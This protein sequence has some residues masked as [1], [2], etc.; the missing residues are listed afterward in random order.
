[1]ISPAEVKQIASE[2]RFNTANIE[3]VLRLIELLSEIY[4][5]PYLKSRF[6]LKGGTAINVF[7]FDIPRLSV[8]IDLNYI[9]S[10]EKD[11]MLNE[12]S[13]IRG[14]LQRI[15]NLQRYKSDFTEN[16]GSDRFDLWYQNIHGNRDRIKLEINYLLRVPLLT[17]VVS[18]KRKLFKSIPLPKVTLL[19]PEE[20]FATKI[21]ALFARHAARDLYD[22]YHLSTAQN[23][24]LN[25]SLLKGCT[26]F[27][28]VIN[29]ED[30]RKMSIDIIDRITPLDIKRTLYPLLQREL[31]F[32]LAK[33]KQRVRRS[34]SPL[35]RFTK[36]E[37]RFIDLFFEGKYEPELIF[38]SRSFSKNIVKHPMVEWKLSHIMNHLNK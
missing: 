4:A 22:I 10:P 13:V 34:L 16:Y 27:Y 25:K 20:L 14:H 8:D 28:G 30:Y 6:V 24:K 37:K 36:K 32:N 35:F 9:G 23:S 2:H 1:V 29:R 7:V 15:Y 31:Q 3:K 38:N 21:I 26:I 19:A 5:H 33:S 17:P 11:V 18:K 12:R